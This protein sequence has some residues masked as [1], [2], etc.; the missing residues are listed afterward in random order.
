MNTTQIPNETTPSQHLEVCKLKLLEPGLPD[1]E[2]AYIKQ[3][4]A[5]LKIMIEKGD[6]W[7]DFGDGDLT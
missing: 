5:D 3:E 6:K 1:E 2:K 7:L 4:I